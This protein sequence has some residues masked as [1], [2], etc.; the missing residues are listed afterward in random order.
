MLILFKKIPF[1][2]IYNTQE[3]FKKKKMNVLTLDQNKI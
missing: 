2:L 1:T 3:M